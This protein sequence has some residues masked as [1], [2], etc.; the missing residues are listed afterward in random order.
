MWRIAKAFDVPFCLLI[1]CTISLTVCLPSCPDAE[2]SNNFK[3][4]SSAFTAKLDLQEKAWLKEH[5][6]IS[7]G[8]MDAWPP[9]NFVD[10]KGKDLGSY[11]FE[12]AFA[13]LEHTAREFDM[14][15]SFRS[16]GDE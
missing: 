12:E 15:L 14:P 1:V 11:A 7:I 10:T 9:M 13:R 4:L 16:E 8:I 5:P 3:D 6:E 2:I